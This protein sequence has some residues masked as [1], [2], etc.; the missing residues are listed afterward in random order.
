MFFFF[1]VEI[2]VAEFLGY[3]MFCLIRFLKSS[4]ELANSFVAQPN[5]SINI[6]AM[7]FVPKR[8]VAQPIY[9]IIKKK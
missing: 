2:V 8:F 7:V 1:N 4:Q 9:R 5:P 3:F 6:K